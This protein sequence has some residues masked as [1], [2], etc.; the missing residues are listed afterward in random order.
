MIMDLESNAQFALHSAWRKLSLRNISDIQPFIVAAHPYL[1]DGS[2]YE[3]TRKGYSYAFHLFQEGSGAVQV[4][5]KKYNAAKGTLIFIPPGYEH[6]FQIEPGRTLNAYNVYFHL[7]PTP[8]GNT[9]KHRFAYA[10]DHFLPERVMD[11]P[12]LPELELLP[13][14]SSLAELPLLT[15]HFIQN[16]KFFQ[17]DLP[18]QQELIKAYWYAWILR[19][20]QEVV[21][22]RYMDERITALL[23]AVE[24]DDASWRDSQ[25]WSDYCGLGKSYFHKLFKRETGVSPQ[26][27]LIRRK[28][29]KAAML[30]VESQISITEVADL[31]EYESIHFFTRQFTAH[32]GISPSAYRRSKRT[33]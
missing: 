8:D 12:A 32:F 26:Q 30:L 11:T 28:L 18:Y 20:Y 25:S 1:Y 24:E 3:Q 4:Q 6:A 31:L 2:N 5:G 15:E 13:T 27:Y 19:W 22:P 16:V 33:T 29:N 14:A 7:W 17:E 9:M 10:S 21:R 23:Q